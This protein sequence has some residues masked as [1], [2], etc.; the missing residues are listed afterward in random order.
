MKKWGINLMNNLLETLGN[1]IQNN[2]WI[3]PFIAFFSGILTSFTPCCLSGIPLII[4]YV[5][6]TGTV[7]PKKAFKLS[8]VFALGSAVTLTSMGIVAALI[9]KIIAFTGEWWHIVLSLLLIVL[10]LQFWEI[11]NVIPQNSLVSKNKKRGYIGALI[12]GLLA[13]LFSSACS[14]PVLI[15]LLAMVSAKGS[16]IFGVVLLL[17]YS[18]G[19]SILLI[20][21]GTSFGFV[22]KVK[23]L[24]NYERFNNIIRIAFGILMIALAAYMFYLGIQ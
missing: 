18:I 21:A 16:L 3:A 24:K 11:I 9:G 20:I 10:V 7:E 8:L 14:T 23:G 13:G 6:N 15:V 12:T 4:A 5:G 19:H 1:T 2:Y 17:L 22:S